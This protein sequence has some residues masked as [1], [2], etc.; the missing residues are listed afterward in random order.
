MRQ[1]ERDRTAALESF[2]GVETLLVI[3]SVLSHLTQLPNMSSTMSATVLGSHLLPL[4]RFSLLQVAPSMTTAVQ[5]A[6]TSHMACWRQAVTA[7]PAAAQSSLLLS[8]PFLPDFGS[9]Q[10]VTEALARAPQVAVVYRGRGSSRPST[11]RVRGSTVPARRTVTQRPASTPR[12]QRESRRVQPY[13]SYRPDRH[14]TTSRDRRAHSLSVSAS[15]HRRAQ[16][17][18]FRPPSAPRGSRR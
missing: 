6:M 18:P 3:E 14:S 11:S 9:Q 5:Q 12:H 7:F 10:A 2:S 8:D 15:T 1:A 13:P 4:V 17:Q 16:T